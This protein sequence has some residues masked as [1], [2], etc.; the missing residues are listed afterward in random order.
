M[1]LFFYRR[2]SPRCLAEFAPAGANGI[3]LFFAVT[4]AGRKTLLAELL[5]PLTRGAKARRS[6]FGFQKMFLRF[7]ENELK[8]TVDWAVCLCFN[9]SKAMTKTVG[10]AFVFR[11]PAGAASRQRMDPGLIPSEPK[12][13]THVRRASRRF[14]L[15]RVKAKGLMEPEGAFPS[16][17][18]N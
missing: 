18:A 7:F 15:R 5:C 8:K 17:S 4:C 6:L 16:G 2:E 1:F 13:R 9:V 12:A 11:E 10:S 14:P 3:K